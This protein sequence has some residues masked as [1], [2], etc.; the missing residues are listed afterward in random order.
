MKSIF[1]DL[2]SC[3]REE[4]LNLIASIVFYYSSLFSQS[5]DETIDELKK[6]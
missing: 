1:N 4:A 2:D 6:L 3:T 5:F